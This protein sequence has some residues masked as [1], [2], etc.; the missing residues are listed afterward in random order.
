[1]DQVCF[2]KKRYLVVKIPKSDYYIRLYQFVIKYGYPLS[3]LQVNQK[4]I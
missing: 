2:K 4:L 1:M 3:E